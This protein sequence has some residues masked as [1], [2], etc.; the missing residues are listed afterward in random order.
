MEKKEKKVEFDLSTLSLKEL[1]E[2]Y[3]E[4]EDYLRYLDESK[5][6]LKEMI[7]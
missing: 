1:I 7:K 4:V 5:T 6:K 2:V 3:K